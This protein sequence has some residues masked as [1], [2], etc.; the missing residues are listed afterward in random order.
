MS[1]HISF[2]LSG[3]TALV[4]GASRGIGQA[5]AIGLAG[6][7]ADIVAV[8]SKAENA[9]DTVNQVEA[10]G[11]KTM[12][13]GCDQSSADAIK[14]AASSAYDLTG[15]IDILVNN[16]GTIRRSPARDYS[17]EDWNAVIDT[18]LT[19][20]FQFCRAI[21]G[22]MIDQGHGKIV[23]IASLLSFQGGITVPAYAASKG[24][25]SQLTKALA[26]EWAPMG[27]QVNAIAPG[28]IATD[29]TAALRANPERNSSILARIPTGRWGDAKDIAGAAVFLA[30][31]ASDYVNGHVLTVD[32]GWMAR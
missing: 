21:G 19:G 18:N 11:R 31:P 12:A 13:L 15:R 29:N 28:Y 14:A 32:G 27:V 6:A 26:N 3:K 22:A 20:V 9:S 7:G 17:D 30:S 25:V 24:G 23:N 4:T 10:L 8:A 16:A 1:S 2:D 5:I